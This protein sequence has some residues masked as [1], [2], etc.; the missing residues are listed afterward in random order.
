MTSLTSLTSY[1]AIVVVGG[2]GVPAAMLAPLVSDWPAEVHLVSL[3]SGLVSGAAGID[4]VAGRLLERTPANAL[5]LGW[6]LGGQVAMSAAQQAPAHIR[7]V[8]TL[9]SFPR[10]VA[11]DEWPYGMAPATFRQFREG[12]QANPQRAWKRFL[13]LQVL[14]LS[15]EKDARRELEPWLADG[16]PLAVSELETSLDWLG[17]TDQR[18]LWHRPAV[19]TR[20]IWGS[21]DYL[22]DAHVADQIAGWG[23]EV[24]QVAGMGHWPRGAAVA[25]CQDEIRRFVSSLGVV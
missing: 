20:H 25:C 9:C 1:P 13:S 18:A 12:L 24:C 19:P 7:G 14:G 16:P 23:G 8:I 10:F 21:L 15:D 3:D 17:A 6:S 5:W 2:W 4:D 11:S 22:V